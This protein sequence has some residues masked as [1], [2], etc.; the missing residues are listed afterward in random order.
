MALGAITF[1]AL[2]MAFD[3]SHYRKSVRPFCNVHQI[4][5]DT[6]I[7]INIENAGMGPMLLQKIVLLKNQNDPIES[8]IPFTKELFS[9]L[10]CDVF[11]QNTEEYVLASLCTLNLFESHNISAHGVMPLLKDKLNGYCL[12]ISYADLYDDTYEKRVVLTL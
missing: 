2:T 11:I 9:E 6:A 3:R 7:G 1:S 12:S 8:A 5:T 10:D 4:V